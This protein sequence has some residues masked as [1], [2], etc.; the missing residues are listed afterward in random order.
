[1]TEELVAVLVTGLVGALPLGIARNQLRSGI[2]WTP[3]RRIWKPIT[4]TDVPFVYWLAVAINLIVGAF[5]VL[6]AVGLLL[7]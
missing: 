3:L 2:A 7:P 1:M 5:L 6:S 4:R